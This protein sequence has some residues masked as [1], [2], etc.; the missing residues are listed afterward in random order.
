V[1]SGPCRCC[2]LQR[3]ISWA[4]RP[5][6]PCNEASLRSTPRSGSSPASRSGAAHPGPHRPGHAPPLRAPPHPAPAAHDSLK[7]HKS[8]FPAFKA[9]QP[10]PQ[11]PRGALRRL[12]GQPPA[13]DRS[14]GAGILE[15][16]GR[17]GW[18][19]HQRSGWCTRPVSHAGRSAVAD[20]GS[21]SRS[22]TPTS[23]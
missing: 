16:L 22:D 19:G 12:V 7:R 10:I 20:T 3:W 13:A 17:V 14:D 1:S 15:G 11:P 21:A 2:R 4:C 8:H 6:W 9:I 5:S 23:P 18:V